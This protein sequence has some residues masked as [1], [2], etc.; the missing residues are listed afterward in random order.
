[1]IARLASSSLTGVDGRALDADLELGV[2][3]RG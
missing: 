1:V 3:C 2:P